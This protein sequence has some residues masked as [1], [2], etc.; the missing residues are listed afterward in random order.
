[1]MMMMMIMMMILTSTCRARKDGQ[2]GRKGRPAGHSTGP[3]IG[4][5]LPDFELPEARGGR[6]S[7]HADRG[8]APSVVLFFR[9]VIW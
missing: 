8:N 4:Y 5:K 1:M 3:E 2:P 9:S 7:Y 6:V